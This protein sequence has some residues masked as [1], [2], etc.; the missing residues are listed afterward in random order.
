LEHV[1]RTKGTYTVKEFQ[2]EAAGAVS[3]A[4]SGTLV[5]ITRRGRPVVHVISEERLAGML[6]TMELLADPEFMC[7]LKKVRSGR[8]IYHPASSLID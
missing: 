3:V 4:E 2:R 8:Q 6:E 7:E 5:T 1:F